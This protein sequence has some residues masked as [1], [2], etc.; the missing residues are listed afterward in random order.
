MKARERKHPWWSAL[1]LF[2][3]APAALQQGGGPE[4]EPPAAAPGSQEELQRQII[5]LIHAVE[6]RLAGIDRRLSDASVGIAPLEKVADSGIDDLLREAAR[7]GQRNVED[8]DRILEIASRL[9][10]NQSNSGSSQQSQMPQGESPLDS[11]RDRGPQERESTPTEPTPQPDHQPK[12]EPRPEQNPPHGENRPGSDPAERGSGT[13]ST[14]DDANRWG[15]LP[16]RYREVFRNQGGAELPVQY[17]EWI[18]A[19]HKRLSKTRR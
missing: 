14:A 1:L 2:C 12:D 5:E 16:V 4:Q 15:E 17:R 10:A 18:D 6:R 19:Y 9:D 8:I 13:A 11:E 7:S 3:A